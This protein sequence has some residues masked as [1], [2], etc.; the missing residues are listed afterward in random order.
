[1][2]VTQLHEKLGRWGRVRLPLLVK[3]RKE[4]SRWM[5]QQRPLQMANPLG[6]LQEGLSNHTPRKTGCHVT[7]DVW[8]V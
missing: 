1:M 5:S 2:S 6:A 7:L 4:S 8:R 3:K